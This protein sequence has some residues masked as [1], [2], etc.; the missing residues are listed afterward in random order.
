MTNQEHLAKLSPEECYKTIN[1]LV[2]IYGKSFTSSE[3]AI[4]EWLKKQ[5]GESQ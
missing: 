2:D 3:I 5:I 1:W 4:I